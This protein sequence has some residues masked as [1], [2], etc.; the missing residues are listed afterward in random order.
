MTFRQAVQGGDARQRRIMITQVERPPRPVA[1][2]IQPE[3]IPSALTRLQQ[4]VLWRYTWSVKQGKWTKRPLT[5]SGGFASSTDPATWTD[6]K[7][8][9]TALPRRVFGTRQFD[10]IGFVV[11]DSDPLCA[12]DLDHCLKRGIPNAWAKHVVGALDSYTEITPSGDGLRIF[13]YAKLPGHG[14]KADTIEIY[15]KQRFLTVTGHT[16]GK[17]RVIG[18]RQTELM[19]IYR[20]VFGK[21]LPDIK[22]EPIDRSGPPIRIDQKLLTQIRESAAGDK[23]SALFDRGEMLSEGDTS[24]SGADNALVCMLWFWLW[25]KGGAAAIDT[26]FR[27]SALMR[28]K[29]DEK[30]GRMTY[31][32]LTISRVIAWASANK[33]Q[34]HGQILRDLRLNRDK[35]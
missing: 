7:T 19:A 8:A 34:Y 22:L 2:M 27:A 10:G 32:E 15:D 24:P 29:W 30:R 11:S 3:N 4:W 9:L 17:P 23:F 5:P 31:G 16:F 26:Y 20:G 28:D 21:P 6:Y 14:R 18:K 25:G 35:Q 12:L 1:P 13:I 33:L